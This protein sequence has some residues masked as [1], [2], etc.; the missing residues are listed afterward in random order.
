VESDLVQPTISSERSTIV[1]IENQSGTTSTMSSVNVIN[2]T[3]RDRLP[4][5]RACTLSMSGQVEITIMVAQTRAVTKG[6]RIQKLAAMRMPMK[7]S[8]NAERVRSFVWETDAF[9]K[10]ILLVV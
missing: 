10:M 3:A 8:A 5:N 6:C 1:T 7:S 4:H 9:I 2:V